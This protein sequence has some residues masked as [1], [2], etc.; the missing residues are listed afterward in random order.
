MLG[1]VTHLMP[2]QLVVGTWILIYVVSDR[3]HVD[4]DGV[5]DALVK[6]SSSVSS[7]R[8]MLHEYALQESRFSLISWVARVAS[9][10]SPGD[11][12]SRSPEA[13]ASYLVSGTCCTNMPF[14]NCASIWYH[15]SLEL[16]RLLIQVMLPQEQ[17]VPRVMGWTGVLTGRQRLELFL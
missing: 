11:C 8:D 4:N 12:P 1:A 9:S 13:L 5:S 17:R 7:L 16:R 14:K 6:G 2:C 15:G 10:S 3:H